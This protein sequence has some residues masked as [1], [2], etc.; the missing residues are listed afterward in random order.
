[1]SNIQEKR[2]L[3]L[4]SCIG[5]YELNYDFAPGA[6]P[7]NA[8]PCRIYVEYNGNTQDS[9]FCGDTQYNGMLTQQG[10]PPVVSNFGKGTLKI[11]KLSSLP[12]NALVT[13]DSPLPGSTWTFT[14]VCPPGCSTATTTTT[15]TTTP[16]PTSGPEP[17][18]TPTP[19]IGPTQPPTPNPTPG[20]TQTPEPTPE[21][22]VTCEE[23]P[24]CCPEEV[25]PERFNLDY[26]FI[27]KN[28]KNAPI[29][30][31]EE[32]PTRPS[33]CCPSSPP[34]GGGDVHFGWNG[35]NSSL[36]MNFFQ[37]H[38]HTDDNYIMKPEIDPSTK[39]SEFD[40][41]AIEWIEKHQDGSFHAIVT[42]RTQICKWPAT[43]IC[44][45]IITIGKPIAA[46]LNDDVSPLLAPPCGG[47]QVG[48]VWYRYSLNLKP[49]LF[50]N[51][52]GYGGV[53]WELMKWLADNMDNVGP[54]GFTGPVGKRASFWASDRF[55]T[56][57]LNLNQLIA[58][59]EENGSSL[60]TNISPY[61]VYSKIKVL[62]DRIDEWISSGQQDLSVEHAKR[63]AVLDGL[64]YRG[65]PGEPDE[66]EPSLPPQFVNPQIPGG[67]TTGR[68]GFPPDHPC[69]AL[70]DVEFEA[71][72]CS[73]SCIEDLDCS[74][75][76]CCT[77]GQCLP[78]GTLI[79]QGDIDCPPGQCCV[80]GLC[81]PCGTCPEGFYFCAGG[82]SGGANWD[83]YCQ[84]STVPCLG[85]YCIDG[86]D[87]VSLPLIPGTSFFYTYAEC[88]FNCPREWEGE[89]QDDSDD[90]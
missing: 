28:P 46:T 58:S 56:L 76:N 8:I 51:I 19:T 54:N 62:S 83:S 9:G 26:P 41:F 43:T 55:R 31:E 7:L 77:E 88:D 90:Y 25:S 20:P 2:T 38:I 33:N 10:Y 32:E 40:H 11:N 5:T 66:P 16:D 82:A 89:I 75:G 70:N 24:E 17:T 81:A 87:C 61:Y 36:S 35:S 69:C 79:C 60:L 68:G 72:G 67:A 71:G 78:C 86:D 65:N 39:S 84:I 37:Q 12:S 6:N 23:N 34:V 14:L 30:Q 50:K 15:T 13:V 45:Q 22:C 1:M 59:T 74:E 42:K 85:W 44:D 3:N 53:Y 29:T 47:C 73:Y 80:D 4:G 52:L 57:S 49:H 21:P 64:V 48:T 18:S 27:I 63:K